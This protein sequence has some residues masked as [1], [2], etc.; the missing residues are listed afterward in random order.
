MIRLYK[1]INILLMF[2]LVLY[3]QSQDIKF[4]R[5]MV[6]DGLP[7][8]FVHDI[9]QDQ[10]GFMWTVLPENFPAEKQI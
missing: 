6:E 2:P 10:Q 3:P 8:G 5:I 9:L 1:A 4:E 7:N